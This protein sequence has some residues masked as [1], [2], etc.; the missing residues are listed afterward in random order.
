MFPGTIATLLFVETD[1]TYVKSM[2]VPMLHNVPVDRKLS[3]RLI[4]SKHPKALFLLSVF[5]TLR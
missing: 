5:F 1:L 3:V 4:S 2:S